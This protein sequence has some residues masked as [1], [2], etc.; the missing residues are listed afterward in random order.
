MSA[1]FGTRG[2]L[3]GG[4]PFHRARQDRRWCI[5]LQVVGEAELVEALPRPFDLRTLVDGTLRL[6]AVTAG[7]DSYRGR[8]MS[9]DPGVVVADDILMVKA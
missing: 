8:L 9:L 4:G 3:D 5:V 6:R 7:K 2:S 1:T